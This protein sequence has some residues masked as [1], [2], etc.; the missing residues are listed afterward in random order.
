MLYLFP[1][2]YFIPAVLCSGMNH[3]ASSCEKKETQSFSVSAAL[4]ECQQDFPGNMFT[5]TDPVGSHCRYPGGRRSVVQG[6]SA[7]AYRY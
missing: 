5:H 1:Y 4:R 6:P 7:H 2:I 3:F